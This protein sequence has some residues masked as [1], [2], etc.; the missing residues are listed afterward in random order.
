MPYFVHFRWLT[1]EEKQELISLWNKGWSSRELADKYEIDIGSVNR[2]KR[3]YFKEHPEEKKADTLLD[4]QIRNIDK[5]KIGALYKAHW[6]I[7]KISDEMKLYNEE[8]VKEVL[9]REGLL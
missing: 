8:L 2:I 5:G 4:K 1:Q 9:K 7:K 6:D 3:E